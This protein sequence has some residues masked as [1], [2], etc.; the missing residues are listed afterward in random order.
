MPTNEPRGRLRELMK[1]RGL[2][3]V[4]LSTKTGIPQGTISRFDRN[5][6]HEAVHLL[7]LSK[8]FG[9]SINELF[10]EDAEDTEKR[11]RE[12]AHV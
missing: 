1:E 10:E 6:R 8:Y 12:L 7:A 2:T 11:H 5:G 9:I 3:Q 4:E